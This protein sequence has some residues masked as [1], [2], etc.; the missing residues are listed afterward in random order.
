MLSSSC[1]LLE[2]S[3]HRRH[4]LKNSMCPLYFRASELLAIALLILDLIYI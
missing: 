3:R 1:Q 4:V 2:S